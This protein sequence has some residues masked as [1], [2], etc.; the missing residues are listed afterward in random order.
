MKKY[1][2][3]RLDERLKDEMNLMHAL[4]YQ[5]TRKKIS[6]SELIELALNELKKS[7]ELTPNQK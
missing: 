3:I 7:Y 1:V 5:K 2:N 4:L 6:H